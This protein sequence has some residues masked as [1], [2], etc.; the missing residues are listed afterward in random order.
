MTTNYSP[1]FGSRRRKEPKQSNS[2]RMVTELMN[3]QE[4]AQSQQQPPQPAAQPSATKAKNA[5]GDLDGDGDIDWDDLLLATTAIVT[6]VTPRLPMV[7]YLLLVPVAATINV[8]A[9]I[10]AMNPLGDL[11]V[12]AGVLIWF[13]IQGAELEPAWPDLSLKESLSALIRLQR[14]PLEVPA[15]NAELTPQATRQLKRYR[16]REMHQSKRAE[17]LRLAGYGLSLTILCG[18]PIVSST[19][20]NWP[21]ILLVAFSEIGVEAGLRGFCNQ[22]QKLLTPEERAFQ[23]TI[24]GTASRTTFKP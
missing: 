18:G 13:V 24:L 8:Q 23:E 21:L 5:W 9:W 3:A 2:Q 22:A 19:G 14:K 12:V 11:A 20:I 10:L 7:G 15:I 1:R 16:E 4:Q 6:F 17:F